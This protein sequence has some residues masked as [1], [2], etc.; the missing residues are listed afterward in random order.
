MA[1][2]KSKTT[3]KVT[4]FILDGFWVLV[5]SMENWY[6]NGNFSISCIPLSLWP[7]SLL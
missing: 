4:I 1:I 3:Q 6:E 7:G 2:L 5:E